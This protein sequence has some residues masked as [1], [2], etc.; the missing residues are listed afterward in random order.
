MN[1]HRTRGFSL[2]ELL[3]VLAIV[4]IV[5]VLAVP[6]YQEQIERGRRAEGK[7]YLLE[8]ASRQE[9]FYTQYSSYANKI[10]GASGC[11]GADCGLG[12]EDGLSSDGHYKGALTAIPSSCSPTG[13]LC[14]SY[15]L[16]AAAVAAP[17]TCKTL[18]M[19]HAGKKGVKGVSD[20]A[21]VD[22]CWR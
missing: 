5:A 3:I 10:F 11:S 8:L 13:T 17:A 16:E 2:I 15:S 22:Y 6:A 7:A 1:R 9:R 12:M 21:K 20:A 19:D 4:A 18:T 14:V